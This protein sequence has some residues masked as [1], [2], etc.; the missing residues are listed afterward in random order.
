MPATPNPQQAAQEA[1][2]QEMASSEKSSPSASTVTQ[3]DGSA[4]IPSTTSAEE[5]RTGLIEEIEAPQVDSQT[6]M[7]YAHMRANAGGG[8]GAQPGA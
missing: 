1:I 8:Y 5:D 7:A 4:A 6:Q 2:G 3:T